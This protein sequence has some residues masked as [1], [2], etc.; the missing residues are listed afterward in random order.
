MPEEMPT[1]KKRLST[2]VI[3]KKEFKLKYLVIII[4]L[5]R[6]FCFILIIKYNLYFKLCVIYKFRR[7]KNPNLNN[8]KRK[9][10]RL[11]QMWVFL[12]QINKSY[13][14]LYY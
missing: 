5:F 9:C 13:K 7:K 8:P 14:Y 6:L 12:F 2:K 4:I 10:D 1:L 3:K 11:Y